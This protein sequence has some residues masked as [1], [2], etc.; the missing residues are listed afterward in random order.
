VTLEQAVDFLRTHHRAV[1]STFR[2]DG[3]PAM[4]PVLAVVDDHGRVVLSTMEATMKV[5]HLRRDPRVALCVI[6]DTFFGDWV[7]VEGTAEIV[8]LPDAMDLLVDYYRR[9]AGEHPDWEDYRESMVRE[10]RCVVRFTID[11]AGP[12]Q[13]G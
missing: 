8:S 13:A 11:R 6:T 12:S 9:A 5:R 10:G 4:T 2:A 3:R 7:Q 1:I